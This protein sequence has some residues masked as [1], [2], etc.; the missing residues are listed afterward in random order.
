MNE[1]KITG[2]IYNPKTTTTSSGKSITR[3]GL[4]I[5]CGKDKD[6]KSKYGFVDCKYFGNLMT[7]DSLKDIEGYLSVDA[8]EKDGK[9]FSKPEIIVNKIENSTMFENKT[10]TKK[11]EPKEE[12]KEEPKEDE[13]FDDEIPW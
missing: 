11:E 4:S 9:K 12:K 7:D 2:K 8:W 6:G 13:P 3:F 10:A 1:V 5:Y